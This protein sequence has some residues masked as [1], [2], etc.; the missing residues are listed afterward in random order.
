MLGGGIWISKYGGTI[1]SQRFQGTVRYKTFR[2]ASPHLSR[3]LEGVVGL[4]CWFEKMEQVFEICKC[5]EDDKVKFV[6]CTF[7]GRALTWWNGNVQTLGFANANLIPGQRDDI[8]AYS[9]RFHELVLICP[10][11]VSTE[12][13]KIEKYI[14]LV[15]LVEQS[16][17][18]MVARIGESNKRKWEDHQ[19]NTNSNNPN[20]NNRNLNNNYHQQQNIRQEAARAYAAAPAEGKVYAGN[21]PLCNKCTFH[22]NG[23]CTVKSQ[24]WKRSWSLDPRLVKEPKPWKPVGWYDSILE[25]CSLSRRKKPIKILNNMGMIAMLDFIPVR[26]DL[27]K[28]LAKVGAVAYRLELPQEL[29]KVHHTF[30]DPLKEVACRQTISRSVGWTP[31]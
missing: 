22:H 29:S 24:N 17:Q 23:Q 6:V 20:N 11:L 1:A 27:F 10:E 5:A 13:K 31:Y 30:H 25:G 4:K 28:V 21:L 3:G 7:E 18:G 16:V 19:R 9:N 2:T 8:E 26:L 12:N 14:H 15:K